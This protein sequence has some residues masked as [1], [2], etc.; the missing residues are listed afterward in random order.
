MSKSK[1]V[2]MGLVDAVGTVV[3]TGL[4]AFLMQNGDELFGKSQFFG[5][6]A[7]LLLFMLSALITSSLVLGRPIFMFLD[8]KKQEAAA[9]LIYTIVFLALM[10]FGIL[11]SL[12][13]MNRF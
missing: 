2:L 11:A 4:V 3:Y 12:A 9:L 1:I 7:F 8:G 6:I 13:A 5:P 10:T